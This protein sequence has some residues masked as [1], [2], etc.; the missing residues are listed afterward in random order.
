MQIESLLNFVNA[1]TAEASAPVPEDAHVFA[2]LL[3]NATGSPPGGPPLIEVPLD[4]TVIQGANSEMP[5]ATEKSPDL[6]TTELKAKAKFDDEK[7][8]VSPDVHALALIAGMQFPA[9]TLTQDVQ[10]TPTNFEVS[11]KAVASEA[12]VLST[13]DFKQLT[14]EPTAEGRA[15]ILAAVLNTDT[16]VTTRPVEFSLAPGN[17]SAGGTGVQ[18]DP[19]LTQVDTG[20]QIMSPDQAAKL[21]P[22]RIVA[23]QEPVLA[24]TAQK[25]AINPFTGEILKPAEV[26][27][28]LGTAIT[29]PV[30]KSTLDSGTIPPAQA[31]APS[32]AASPKETKIKSLFAFDDRLLNAK[33]AFSEDLDMTIRRIEESVLPLPVAPT[34]KPAMTLET[35]LQTHPETKLIAEP[36]TAPDA[37]LT[38]LNTEQTEAK[39]PEMTFQ[40]VGT[41][42]ISTESPVED[43][44]AISDTEPPVASLGARLNAQ[45]AENAPVD[46]RVESAQS[47]LDANTQL[48]NEQIVKQVV[49]R[50][51]HFLAM[52]RD[53]AITIHLEPRELGSITLTIQNTNDGI[54]AEI[55]ASNHQVQQ[56]LEANKASLVQQVENKGLTLGSL[57]VT[58]SDSAMGGQADPQQTQQEMNRQAQMTR[59]FANS[60]VAPVANVS[61]SSAQDA[62]LNYVI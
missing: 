22:V 21:N 60:D 41:E 6:P 25:P 62:G 24:P 47:K 36:V 27:I 37:K 54:K 4:P 11:A 50:A 61:P 14:F 8:Q 58:L 30:L 42:A 3:A 19:N 56:S 39:G 16:I 13:A 52:K 31:K 43:L 59:A 23:T 34:A 5:N 33:T 46:A 29:A 51:D 48:K 44:K 9:L 2:G 7:L 18:V 53:G 38:M 20:T 40:L 1:Q 26:K 10:T 49:E 35:L 15:D 28:D 32:A 55:K 12:P 45:P 57:N 17:P